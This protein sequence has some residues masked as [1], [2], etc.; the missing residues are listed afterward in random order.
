MFSINPYCTKPALELRNPP[1][2]FF[3]HECK[4][5]ELADTPR[6]LQ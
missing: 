3:E 6:R 2:A 5:F 4:K 1:N